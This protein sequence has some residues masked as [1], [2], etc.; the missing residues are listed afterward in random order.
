V[1]RLRSLG[2]WIV[3][4][5]ATI[6][7]GVPAIPI[8]LAPPRGRWLF[9]WARVWS[10]ILLAAAGARVRVLHPERL[11]ASRA[12]V[13]TPNHSSFFDIP[14]LFST[15]PRAIGFLAKRN[16][17]RL[18]FMGWAMAAGGFVPVDRGERGRTLATID[19]ALRR[20]EHGRWLVVFPEET[21]TRTGDLL[22]FKA[23]AALLAIRSG[24]PILPVGIAGTFGIQKRGEFTISP[25]RVAVAIGEPMDVAGKTAAD[26]AEI[27]A[28]LRAAVAALLEEAE[29]SLRSGAPH[30]VA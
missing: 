10:R 23:G 15:M 21:R 26:R 12:F 20:L 7:F 16:L 27:T 3:I 24:R 11:D 18:P 30:G 1:R 5:V 4:V 28:N 8:G 17:F 14:V 6:F 29:A 9:H 22:P 2:V 19:A 25:S 13:V